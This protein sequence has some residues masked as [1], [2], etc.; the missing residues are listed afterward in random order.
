M[1]CEDEPRYW[2]E[3]VGYWVGPRCVIWYWSRPSQSPQRIEGLGRDGSC[4]SAKAETE[5]KNKNSR[6]FWSRIV[7][8]PYGPMMEVAPLI[9]PEA[10]DAEI[11]RM[12][13]A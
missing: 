1:H 3:M 2:V 10:I 6:A 13:Q 4:A 12:V 5:S 7:P 9:T 11:A 8:R